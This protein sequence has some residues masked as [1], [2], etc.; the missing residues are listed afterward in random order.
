MPN[1]STSLPPV[2]VPVQASSSE[3]SSNTFSYALENPQARGT[4]E[5]AEH[6]SHEISEAELDGRS[7]PVS[8]KPFEGRNTR[9][10]G[11]E[12]AEGRP[13]RVE[14]IRTDTLPF[15]RTRHLRNPWNHGREVKVS[16]DGTEL[17][18]TVGQQLLDD[19]DRPPVAVDTSSGHSR[20][21][22]RRRGPKSTQH[23]P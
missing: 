5:P 13:F 7:K 4:R 9:D 23:K 8:E 20:T 18:P 3:F 17:E 10:D 2:V 1:P 21:T 12:P 15:F 19:W 6:V 16:R 22:E 14:W 11:T